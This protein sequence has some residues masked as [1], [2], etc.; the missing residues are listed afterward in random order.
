[1]YD[2][3]PYDD[4]P[5]RSSHVDVLA[6]VG[7]LLG[8][9]PAPPEACRVLELGAGMGGNLLGMAVSLPGSRF[10]GVDLSS[11]Q[12]AHARAEV[13]ALGLDNIEFLAVDI[14]DLGPGLGCFDYILCHGVWS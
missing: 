8:L 13:A 9:D 5:F 12:I 4:F 6:T 10:A 1:M 3:F 11:Q 2:D 14:L 7:G